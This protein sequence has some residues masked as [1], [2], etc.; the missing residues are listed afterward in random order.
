VASPAAGVPSGQLDHEQSIQG[1]RSCISPALPLSRD[2]GTFDL[3]NSLLGV[4]N[5][6]GSGRVPPI[7]EA[8]SCAQQFSLLQT[9]TFLRK[10]R[11]A[12]WGVSVM[13]NFNTTS[14]TLGPLGP[15]QQTTVPKDNL[16]VLVE[17]ISTLTNILTNYFHCTPLYFFT[18]IGQCP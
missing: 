7:G 16:F 1:R 2:K 11:A 14:E 4:V 8:S 6:T 15:I 12:D 9:S 18:S 10:E 5:H 13:H 17:D 3:R